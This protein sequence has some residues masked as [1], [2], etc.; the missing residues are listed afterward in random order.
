MIRVIINLEYLLNNALAPI[1]ENR[2]GE[3]LLSALEKH[4]SS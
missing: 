4:R 3:E 1:I 2:K